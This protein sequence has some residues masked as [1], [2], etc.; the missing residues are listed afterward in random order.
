MLVS[1]SNIFRSDTGMILF[2]KG[3]NDTDAHACH[4]RHYYYSVVRTTLNYF[5]RINCLS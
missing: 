2:S 5:Q 4:A 3:K 1:S